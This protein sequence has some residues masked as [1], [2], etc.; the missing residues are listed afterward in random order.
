MPDFLHIL[1]SDSDLLNHI[2]SKQCKAFILCHERTRI[3]SRATRLNDQGASM[4]VERAVIFLKNLILVFQ[5][6]T[7]VK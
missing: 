4:P 6:L 7:T 1:S 3:Q 2:G 5:I